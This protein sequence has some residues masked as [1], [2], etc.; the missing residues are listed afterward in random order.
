[1][2]RLP[3]ASSVASYHQAGDVNTKAAHRHTVH[4]QDL[5]MGKVDPHMDQAN[6]STKSHL[7]L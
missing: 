6:T 1:M 7:A 4:R 3:A 2:V 5:C